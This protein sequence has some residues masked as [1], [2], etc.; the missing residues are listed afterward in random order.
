MN[1]GLQGRFAVVTA[2]SRGLGFA[3]A[4][5]IAAEGAAVMICSRDRA[6]IRKA[7]AAIRVAS[8]AA[9]VPVVADV[10]RAAGIRA[11]ERSAAKEFGAVDILVSNAGGPPRGEILTLDDRAWRRGFELTLMST[12]RLIRAFLPGMIDR[13]WGRIVTITSIAAKQPINDLLLSVAFR[14]GVHGLSK[15]VSNRHAASNVT[16]NTVCPGYILTAR[17]AELFGARAT[18]EGRS[19]ASIRR[20]LAGEVP[21]GRLGRPEEVGEVIAFLAS[22]RASYI[23]GVNLLVDGGMAK[24]IY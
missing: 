19:G 14:P 17:Q 13:K 15:V 12:V 8:G 1:L 7:A 16:V 20:E 22:E 10:S 11:L 23:N 2:S 9:V 21:T 24:G 6:A 18:A 4:S 5:A 3:A